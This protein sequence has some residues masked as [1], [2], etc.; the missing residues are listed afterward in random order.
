MALVRLRHEAVMAQPA[1]AALLGGAAAA[2]E[3]GEGRGVFVDATFGGG[4]HSR[5]VLREMPAAARLLALDCDEEAAVRAEALRREG[6]VGEGRFWFV[7]CNYSR[8]GEVVRECG[9]RRVCGVLFDL[10]VSSLQ[11]DEA[12]R[13][14]SFMAD[15]PLDMRMDRRGGVSA[16][17]WLAQAR[18]ED[19]CAVLRRFGEEPEARRVARALA[20][21]RGEIV[22]TGDLARVVCEAKKRRAP[23]G[24]HPATRV[25]MA[26]RMAVNEELRHLQEGLAAARRVLVVGGRLVV[27]AFHSLEDRMVKRLAVA[28]ALPRLGR[29]AGGDLAPVGRMRRACAAE[30]A[31]NPR[32]RSACL[33]VFEKVARGGGEEEGL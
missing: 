13:G 9:P 23:A 21:R 1:V 8:L 22:R 4:G 33:R 30:V 32:A 28:P 26:L 7:R 12:G 5:L 27:I 15:A 25:F 10:G 31:A 2:A 18:E 11:L 16:A 14:F 20:A 19:V 6:G 17:E 3:G 29:V 24:R